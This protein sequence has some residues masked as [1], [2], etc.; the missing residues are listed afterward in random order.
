M[1]RLRRRIAFVSLIS[2]SLSMLFAFTSGAATPALAQ[3]GNV[4]VANSGAVN[5]RSGPA[6][7]TTILGSVPGGTELAVTGRNAAGTWWRVTSSFGVGWV[8]DVVVVFRGSIASVPV[9]DEPKGTVQTPIILVD[10]HA[11]TVYR[12][13]NRDSFVIG[14]APTG[15]VLVVTGRSNDGN[16]WQVET[17][18][19]AGFVNIATVSF[20]GDETLVPRVSDPGP[21]FDG[22]TV[23]VNT[24]TPVTTQPGGGDVI[25]TLPAGT[26]MPTG[27]R[28]VDNTWWQVAANFGIGWIPVSN[29]S[30]AGAAANI[31]VTSNAIAPKGAYTGAAFA[32][33]IIEADRKVA[34]NEATFASPPMWDTHLGDQGGVVARSSDGLWL[35]VTIGGYAGWVNFSGITLQGN[36]AS[37][38][39]VETTP[40]PIRNIAVVNVHR[41]NIRSGPGADFSDLGSVPG[42]TELVVTGRHP[43]LP[44]LRVQSSF[45][46][47]W[48][49]IMWVIFRGNWAAVPSVTEPAGTVALPIA[50][51]SINRTVYALPD[52]ASASQL[53]PPGSY[54]ILGRTSDF[55]WALLA[56]PLGNVWISY[57]QFTLRGI[58]AAIPV[59]Q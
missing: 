19:G 35:Q 33:V 41:L 55:K 12:N 15:A 58:E 5:I 36:M 44:W 27:G 46:V 17:P 13:P 48:V 51:V 45:G 47:G 31:R 42:G 2:L 6:T 22:P 30:L 29:V 32:S 38:P 56:T 26:T 21:S 39:V 49:R 52:P 8:S 18:M 4:V 53:L 54:T 10:G 7:N 20:R 1:A 9:V 14:I 16:W 57:A 11:A 40:A 34:Y 37:I 25:G 23:R 28:T 43:T 3:G 50:V 24:D 59:V